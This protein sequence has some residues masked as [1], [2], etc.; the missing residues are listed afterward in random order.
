MV[1]LRLLRQC[2]RTQFAPGVRQER[3]VLSEFAKVGPP[4]IAC[5]TG[6]KQAKNRDYGS[7]DGSAVRYGEWRELRQLTPINWYLTAKDY[8]G[9]DAS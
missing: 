7:D 4:S 6:C 9:R 8:T 2:F 1:M 5:S 3:N